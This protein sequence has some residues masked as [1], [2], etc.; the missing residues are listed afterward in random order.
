MGCFPFWELRLC[1][2]APSRGRTISPGSAE[3]VILTYGYWSRRFGGERSV[4]R[5]TIE[6][7]GKLGTIIGVLPEDFRSPDQAAPAMLLPLKLNRE[8][9]FLGGFDY[10]GI[11]RLKPGVTMEQASTDV[12]RMLPIVNRSFPTLPDY[13]LKLYEDARFGPNL[14]PLKQEVVGDVGKVLWILLGGISLVL[15]IACANVANFL[16]VRAEGRRQELAIRA[17]LGASRGRIAAQLLFESLILAAF[18]GLFGLGLAYGAVRVLIALAP[19]GLPRLN[20]IGVDGYVALFTLGVS[21]VAGLLFGA[22]PVFKFAGAEFG[23]GLR[24]PGRSMSESRERR[25]SRGILVIVQVA[26]ALV[27]LASSGL[28]IRTFLALTGVNPGFV[29]PAEIQTFGIAILDTRAPDAER[30]IQIE[31]EILQKL[32]AIP[33]VS[34]ASISKH[35]P[36]DGKRWQDVVY[37]KN[38]ASTSGAL[39]LRRFHFVAPGFFKTLGTPLLAGR[40]I[41]WS[42][43]Y[44][45]NKVPVAIV[46]ENLAREYWRDPV[47]VA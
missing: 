4:I 39:P 18:G 2:D 34:S 38:G 31:K 15:V 20:E 42:D 33:G 43:I 40:D 25:R 35:I 17:A 14:R 19:Q 24:E 9:T 10:L 27:L 6:V 28:M 26:L 22:A 3:T 29:S 7:N 36:M 47:G 21:M 8:Q 46:S 1:S 45:Y 23:I 32:E 11:A 44:N 41:T 12:A 37:T 30:V 5:K 16:L 13:P